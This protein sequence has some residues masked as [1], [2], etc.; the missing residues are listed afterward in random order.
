MQSFSPTGE[1]RNKKGAALIICLSML[2]LVTILAVAFLATVQTE[3][4]AS[5]H[6]I[7]SVLMTAGSSLAVNL[8]ENQIVSASREA[9]TLWTSQPGLIRTFSL[10]GEPSKAYK[11]YSSDTLTAAGGAPA[12][13]WP[14]NWSASTNRHQWVD[15]NEPTVR[16]GQVRYPIL[17][18][19]ADGWVDGF[20]LRDEDLK[21]Q[22]PV[23]WLYV[24]EDGGVGTLDDVTAANPALYRI[25]YWTDDE[26][27][28]VNLNTAGE[29]TYWGIPRTDA[30]NIPNT[31]V[32]LTALSRRPPVQ[33][34]YQ[35][36]PGHPA[37]TSLSPILGRT[38]GL[39]KDFSTLS[40]PAAQTL[41]S[42]FN[43]ALYGVLPRL[44]SGGS[45]SGRVEAASSA[46]ALPLKKERLLSSANELLFAPGMTGET[47][48]RL[49]KLVG[50]DKTEVSSRELDR[51]GFFLT[52]SSRSPDLNAFKLPRVTLWPLHRQ[53]GAGYRTPFD[54][55]IAK[56]ATLGGQAHAHEYYFWRENGSSPT[57]D[58][59]GRNVELYDYLH[60]LLRKPWPGAGES[61]SEKYPQDYSQIL[62]QIVDYGRTINLFDTSTTSQPP[63]PFTP[64]IQTV[65]GVGRNSPGH[66]QVVPL[67]IN[68]TKGFGRFATLGRASLLFI[69]ERDPAPAPK[70]PPPRFMKAVL[71]LELFV[72][73]SGYTYYYPD[74][75]LKV[76]VLQSPQVSFYEANGT[77]T[78]PAPLTLNF[79]SASRRI[80]TGPRMINANRGEGGPLGY[81]LTIL[82]I[83]SGKREADGVASG[84][85]WYSSRIPLPDLKLRPPADMEGDGAIA[86]TDPFDM[87]EPLPHFTLDG[88][89]FAVSFN[90]GSE[91]IQTIN[92]RFPGSGRLPIPFQ[93]TKD[94]KPDALGNSKPY[95]APNTL[96][97]RL[98]G[99]YSEPKPG[100]PSNPGFIW[101]HGDALLQMDLAAGGP[102]G[103]DLRLLAARQN[104]SA[105]ESGSWFA[106]AGYDSS[107]AVAYTSHSPAL[108]NEAIK[109]H[110]LHDPLVTDTK[111]PGY[112]KGWRFRGTAMPTFASSDN[113]AWLP[114]EANTNNSL[115]KGI[116]MIG[117]NSSR[118]IGGQVIPNARVDWNCY[119]PRE[120]RL[121]LNAD[122]GA[123][124]YDAGVLW[125]GPFTNKPDDGVGFDSATTDFYPYISTG[126]VTLLAAGETFS[127]PSRQMP[128]PGVLGSQ[129]TGVKSL[130]PWQ[131]L[132]FS[133][134]P[135]ARFGVPASAGT[136]LPRISAPAVAACP[137]VG[138]R[139]RKVSADGKS[140]AAAGA[141]PDHMILDLFHM[142][143]VEPYA[144]SE[145]FSTA[146]RINM[147]YE[148]RPF[149]HIRRASGMHAVLK[150]LLIQARGDGAMTGNVS[151]LHEVNID[152]TLNNTDVDSTPGKWWKDF[153]QRFASGELFLSASEICEVPLI[154]KSGRSKDLLPA[155][156]STFFAGSSYS[157]NLA[158]FWLANRFTADNQREE[159]YTY[160]YPRLT[161]RSNTFSVHYRVQALSRQF[162]TNPASRNSANAILGELRGSRTIERY[163]DLEAVDKDFATDTS[164]A[165]VEDYYRFREIGA[166][167]F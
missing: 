64:P 4:A 90:V 29:G 7:D 139:N 8:V 149:T 85:P 93:G 147:N 133:P 97:G 127:S 164:G 70:M 96:T 67:V 25:A 41:R 118:Q 63:H 102:S 116:S 76:D 117:E 52:T 87:S 128:S 11:L 31:E 120:M 18:P 145:P 49:S 59:A 126:A 36:Y 130:R 119:V 124:D 82:D 103:G 84:Y 108:T 150:P 17:D 140:V 112:S 1:T 105:L 107:S 46:G 109:T 61:F 28:K 13:E 12:A 141:P 23:R 165:T 123:G 151:Y 2:V 73:Q 22:M 110:L 10:K 53:S 21:A 24:L 160:L 132:L 92:L 95:F 65:A 154:P 91:T 158:S 137:H 9:D 69:E 163:I 57:A 144:I 114:Y 125:K 89:E 94:E 159:P 157:G 80:R 100:S 6:E 3:V 33:W 166:R 30:P 51:L 101:A 19:S 155:L 104:L 167:S 58:F 55:L 74:F 47:R 42:E 142:P 43:E 143:V 115:G 106:G 135:A 62:T 153:E 15:I 81:W 44:S 39:P 79:P 60:R 72:P 35:R 54:Q 20:E 40:A 14:Q 148:I 78:S 134:V 71:L 131:T 162:S 161:T 83:D 113:H 86:A 38:L 129:P 16:E 56:A 34:E 37:T 66:G 50:S 111:L 26:S 75:D 146:G 32:E 88:A 136:G 121:A 45:Q 68:D 138:E 122:Q 77:P 5:R 48:P 152:A 27:C 156:G 99:R 98:A